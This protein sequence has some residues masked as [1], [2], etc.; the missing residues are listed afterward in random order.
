LT[1]HL[2]NICTYFTQVFKGWSVISMPQWLKDSRWKPHILLG[3]HNLDDI[4]AV[5]II[6]S[7]VIPRMQYRGEVKPL[8]DKHACLRAIVCVVDDALDQHPDVEFFCIELGLGLYVYHPSLGLEP[9]VRI[10]SK[11]AP[12][13]ME[14]PSEKGWFPEAILEHTRRLTNLSF[15]NVIHDFSNRVN[16]FNN[17]RDKTCQLIKK[18]IDSLMQKHPI[19][20]SNVSHFM[21]L[22]HFEKLFE[23][24]SPGATDHVLH[25]FRV[26]LAGCAIIDS[27]YNH[28]R[29]AHERYQVGSGATVLV[30]REMET[31]IGGL[32]S[33]KC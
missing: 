4:I 20:R 21:K 33:S 5:D 28:F 23:L 7:G 11:Q 29:E 15:R 30:Q 26:F 3:K 32:E 1:R 16:T 6:S 31:S 8:L 25:S 13:S 19:F 22:H 9:V 14:L 2:K 10:D 24:A 27:F 12:L 18:T 17:D